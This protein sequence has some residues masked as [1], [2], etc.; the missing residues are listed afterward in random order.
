[1]WISQ[2]NPFPFLF[3]FI[4]QQE[5]V[6]RLIVEKGIFSREELLGMVRVVD[7]E[8]K[9]SKQK[10]GKNLDPYIIRILIFFTLP[11]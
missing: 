3:S 1:V 5:A 7:R 4:A 6:G 11:N 10:K 9:N 2:K 8:M